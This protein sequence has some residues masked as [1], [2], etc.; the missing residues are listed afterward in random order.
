MKTDEPNPKKG[1]KT[2]T[3]LMYDYKGFDGLKEIFFRKEITK[4]DSNGNIVEVS[5][6]DSDMSLNEK[7]IDK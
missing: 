3:R 4:Y 2:E 5:N 7:S 6:Y 1:I